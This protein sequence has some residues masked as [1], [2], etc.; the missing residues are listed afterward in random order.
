LNS[1]VDDEKQEII[2]HRAVHLGIATDTESGLMVPV[3]RDAENLGVLEIARKIAALAK[4]ARDR[5]IAANQLSGSTFTISNVGSLAG[6]FA[7]PI[8]NY[9]ECCILGV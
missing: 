8:I 6:K 5:S 1:T 7:T 9:P 3:I 4:S 2:Q